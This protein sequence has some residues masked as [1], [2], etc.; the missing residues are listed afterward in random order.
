M[1]NRLTKYKAKIICDF[2]EKAPDEELSTNRLRLSSGSSLRNT[3]PELIGD[4]FRLEQLLLIILD[5]Y[6]KNIRSPACTIYVSTTFN[7]TH[8]IIETKCLQDYE[9]SH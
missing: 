7:G 3:I 8:L 2:W 4:V 6:M 1:K 9:I 5:E